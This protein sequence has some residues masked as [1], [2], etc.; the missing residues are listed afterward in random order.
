MVEY[1]YADLGAKTAEE[2][3]TKLREIASRA[4]EAGLQYATDE[5]ASGTS[6]R[7]IDPRVNVWDLGNDPMAFLEREIALSKSI[8]R[9]SFPRWRNPVSGIRK[10]APW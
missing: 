8:C 1:G 4:P 2:E 3:V 6:V 5:D 10:S 9:M 7:S